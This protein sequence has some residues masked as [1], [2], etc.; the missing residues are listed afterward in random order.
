[1]YI[2]PIRT[3]SGPSGLAWRKRRSAGCAVLCLLLPALVFFTTFPAI[4]SAADDPPVIKVGVFQSEP[5]CFRDEQGR[6]AGVFPDVIRE[7][8]Q[9]EG[10]TLEFEFNEL[11][12]NLERLKAGDIDLMACVTPS[13]ERDELY[14][15]SSESV[16]TAWGVVYAPPN[17]D[18]QN[19]LDMDGRLTAVM[20]GDING[21]HFLEACR[22][23]G[24]TC[25]TVEVESYHAI[26]RMI[27]TGQADAG[28][29]NNLN[30]GYLIRGHAVRPTSIL[31]DPVSAGY[32]APKGMHGDLLATID[33]RLAEWKGDRDSVYYRILDHYYGDLGVRSHV[34]GRTIII[35]LG[36]ALGAG[37]LLFLWVISLRRRVR[38]KT[39][40]LSEE[41]AFISAAL[42]ANDDVFLVYEPLT[43]K[44]LR[45][46]R[47]AME[48]GGY[49]EEEIRR[50]RI[51][52]AYHDEEN[53]ARAKKA[54]QEIL[55]SG[56]V[57]IELDILTKD[58]RNLP[59]EYVASL[60]K[61]EQGRPEYI[62]TLGRDISNRRQTEEA[63][64]RSEEMY[65][66]VME[67][68]Y[69]PIVV[70]DLDGLATFINPAFTRVFGWTPEELIGRQ[71]DFVPEE[72]KELTVRQ[73]RQCLAEGKLSDFETRRFT[74]SGELIEVN[75]SAAV[76]KDK[77]G[78]TRGV[79]VNLNDISDRKRA[80]K[81]LKKSEAYY[82]SLF[83]NT[84]A[85]A[86]IFSDDTIIRSCNT[87]YANLT[88]YAK[89][90]IE[91]KLSWTRIIDP[92]DLRRLLT[93]HEK[94]LEGPGEIPNEYEFRL[95]TRSGDRRTVQNRLSIVPGTRE[96]VSSLVDIT[97]RKE[98]EKK[99]LESERLNR[100]LVEN[101][102]VPI[103]VHQDEVF[104][105]VN[106][107][108]LR[109]LKAQSQDEYIGAPIWD[110]L[111][112]DSHDIARKRVSD[113]YRKR[114][115][116]PAIEQKLIRRDGVVIDAE[117]TGTM[118]DHE[119]RP[120]S[121]TMFTDITRRKEAERELKKNEEFMQSIFRA[122]PT[123]I[124]VLAD[125]VYLSVNDRLSEITG[126]SR[127][128]LIGRST[129]LMYRCDEEYKKFG[130]IIYRRLRETGISSIEMPHRRKN[131]EEYFALVTT[132]PLNPDEPGGPVTSAIL[133]VTDRKKAEEEIIRYRNRLEELVVERT[134]EL[135][136]VNERLEAEVA[137]RR[138]VEEA[139]KKSEEKY[140]T[141]FEHASD[142]IILSDESDRIVDV[143]QRL[144]DLLGYTREE[145]LN[146][147]IKDLQAPEVR[148]PSGGVAK[149]EYKLF[150]NRPFE[151][152]DV[153]KDGTRIPIE[154]TTSKL[155]DRLFL[156]SVRN[157]SE[158]KQ[159][160][161]ALQEAKAAAERANQAKSEFLAN[162]SHEIR[163]PMNAVVG[164]SELMLTT[165]LNKKQLEY[166][167]A[168]SDSAIALLTILDDIL[169]FSRI[170]AGK[171][172]L[173]NVPFNLRSVM[174]RVGRTLAF[175]TQKKN[176]EVLIRYPLEIPAGYLGD[177][178]RVMQILMN[179]AGNAVKFTEQGHVLL[180]VL[181]EGMDQNACGLTFQVSDTG[182]GIP[183][184]RLER[185]FDQF[186]QADESITR[187]Y[188]GT[189]L[190]LAISKQ[191]VEMMGG[192]ISVA[193][194]LGEGSV[195]SFNLNLPRAP[196]AE[197]QI[198]ADMDFDGL[199][200]LV[201]DDNERNRTIVREYLQT[202]S[203]PCLAVETPGAALDE[204]RA[205]Q[206]KGEAYN[207][208]ILDYGMPEMDGARLARVIKND[209][210]ISGA[211]LILLS[212]CMPVDE[213]EPET[214]AL[215]AASLNKPIKASL[216]FETLSQ[217]WNNRFQEGA[218]A[219]VQPSPAGPAEF[220]NFGARVL[221]VEDSAMNQMV[222][223]EILERFG[224][225]VDTAE[226]GL[227]ALELF[228]ANQYDIIFM[229]VQMPV[230]DGF[231]AAAAIRASGPAGREIP[232]V[233]MTAMA[234]HGDR[235][236]CLAAGM[237]DYVSKPIRTAA[238][239]EAL[240][241]RLSP[242]TA[243]TV[244][245]DG[246]EDSGGKPL[247]LNVENLLDISGQDPDIIEALIGEY[248]GSAPRYFEELA[249]AVEQG[250]M[251][252]IEKKVH[253]LHGLAANAGG[254]RVRGILSG[255]EERIRQGPYIPDNIDLEPLR[256]EIDRLSAALKE[257]DWKSLCRSEE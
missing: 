183:P 32:T 221:L 192:A 60:K 184:D 159:V 105:F 147:C 194:R 198:A 128:E 223:T 154:V 240:L 177:P 196:E 256:A 24:V 127:E 18:I 250:E 235:E 139:V 67:A 204:L 41:Q 239:R 47:A 174:E 97:L 49:T 87:E 53:L 95:V 25:R 58:G 26:L 103:M 242:Q 233:A 229:D 68:S 16:G 236:A 66:S 12:S 219:P 245:S 69:Q 85:A 175:R 94:R 232:I 226:H 171:L 131:G 40:E 117:V 141:L 181:L 74:K 80:E 211:H 91:G 15:F 162:M 132:S 102:P 188:G 4:T 214:K 54:Y 114:G 150:G 63:L 70:Y 31:F 187:N 33:R 129:R 163:T 48:I 116:A 61:D 190:G 30:G 62:I 38:A 121:L 231:E 144:S 134:A 172:A 104:V 14:D 45:W 217:V 140:R 249:E 100:T 215:F 93:Y 209:S 148:L 251:D 168:I 77:D 205:A 246:T 17:S 82:R 101:S 137:E 119:G 34:F 39:L 65:R 228:S 212:S 73:V 234:M 210:A 165:K 72:E 257:T 178:T 225:R 98:A 195:F 27:E 22:G 107:A 8:A 206:Q 76:H 113:L 254:E 173:E 42:D 75:I 109:A 37:L 160:E 189:G 111:H 43:G 253:R 89:S 52:H 133:D 238:V 19:I 106:S 124:A 118:M 130:E 136:Q 56:R 149:G 88:G 81:E 180:E 115:N 44:P 2:G 227:A 29:M 151:A 96:R 71:I 120:A 84:G 1:M 143:N 59:T 224:C 153:H 23:F 216:F 78:E 123:G 222:A 252:L 7:I 202:R 142:A 122:A 92:D 241:R 51:P 110:L 3:T 79:V 243:Q 230:M 108:A 208:A 155:A 218:V 10:W 170:Q 11:T 57:R 138:R 199:K 244:G 6:I 20:R 157:I 220:N 13:E 36:A 46:N 197:Q 50:Q 200:V 185:I 166:A 99:I 145:L 193:S 169:D 186:S 176:V 28:V 207:T 191:L 83:E 213:L 248:M 158:R 237:D 167:E 247:V 161:E 86:C 182:V 9:A 164:M 55:R 201:V 125:R 146:M 156:S 90:E 255:L 152:L 35:I 203:I 126:F 21:V 179:L 5:L 135:R 112:P 64:R